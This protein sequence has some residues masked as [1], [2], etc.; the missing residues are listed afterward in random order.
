MARGNLNGFKDIRIMKDGIKRMIADIESE[1]K[2]TQNMIGK[3]ALDKRVMK[4]MA[5]VPRDVFVPVDLKHAAFING[6][7]PIGYGQTIS[8]PYIVALMTD[9]LVIEPEH[10]ILE[11]GTGSGYQ[12]AILSQLCKQVYTVEYIAALSERAAAHF[13]KLKY[14]NIETII[15]NGC[16]G[17]PEHAPYDGIIV[18]A[19]A[20]R[21][22]EALIEQ[23]KPGGNLVIPVRENFMI[24]EL[25]LVKKDE[26]G[27]VDV[28]N[29]LGV[30]FV[31]LV[32][33]S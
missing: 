12:T 24:Q 27:E 5:Q 26:Q 9:M 2:F 7:L 3:N 33:E 29:V 1:V 8:Q 14:S 32:G 6:P 30:A 10:T 11:I 19:A 18:T 28:N 21:I 16:K 17:W 22:P 4:A 13:R 23:L 20:S 31:P 25:K 15:G